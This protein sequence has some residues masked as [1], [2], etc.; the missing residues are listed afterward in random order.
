MNAGLL[1]H[2]IYLQTYTETET[3]P[4]QT[5]KVW[6]TVASLRGKIEPIDGLI[7]FDTMQ[8]NQKITHKITIRYHPGITSEHWL[9]FQNRR[10]RIRSVSN[11]NELNKMLVLLCEEAF[12]E[13]KTF[14]N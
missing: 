12:P 3:G 4:Y 11:K 2:C 13:A 5:E 6:T 9:L 1:R 8:I 7:T 10:F 14:P